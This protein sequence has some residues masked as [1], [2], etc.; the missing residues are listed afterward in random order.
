MSFDP[1]RR[2]PPTRRR[3]QKPRSIDPSR[4]LIDLMVRCL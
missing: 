2:M 1:S 4:P 3:W